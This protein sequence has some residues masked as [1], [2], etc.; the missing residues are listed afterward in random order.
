MIIEFDNSVYGQIRKNFTEHACEQFEVLSG[1]ELQQLFREELAKNSGRIIEKDNHGRR[2]V[3]VTDSLGMCSYCDIVFT[4][5]K[6]YVWFL[7]KW[8]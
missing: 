2:L 4:D 8:T 5:E 3:Y 1:Q 6:H 7:L